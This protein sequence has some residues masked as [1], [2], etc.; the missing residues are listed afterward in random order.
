MI[1]F[2]FNALIKNE[3][4]RIESVKNQKNFLKL[5]NIDVVFNSTP[6]DRS[7]YYYKRIFDNLSYIEIYETISFFSN[8]IKNY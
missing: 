1:K 2:M 4:C 3:I 5:L 6:N 8:L 7:Y